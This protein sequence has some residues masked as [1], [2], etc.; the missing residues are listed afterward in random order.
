MSI[1]FSLHVLIMSVLEHFLHDLSGIKFLY[2]NTLLHLNMLILIYVK[3]VVNTLL[4]P[5]RWQSF[6]Q[7]NLD[8][9][10]ILRRY[11]GCDLYISTA[12]IW[13]MME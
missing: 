12:N 6:K 11:L 4:T 5:L 9:R 8:K 7:G 2:V 1:Q 3:E 10:K 13:M